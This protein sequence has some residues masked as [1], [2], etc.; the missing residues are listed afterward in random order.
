MAF[1]NLIVC[2]FLSFYSVFII[3]LLS[4]KNRKNINQK[5]K[6]LDTIRKVKYKTLEEQKAFINLKF[7]KSNMTKST[8]SQKGKATLKF[9]LNAII[10]ITI[11]FIYKYM[12]TY[13]NIN[14]GLFGLILFLILFPLIINYILSK[15]KLQHNDDFR[16]IFGNRG[17]KK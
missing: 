5:N 16:I 11:L 1:G 17:N 9:I 8:W 6:K 10:F 14:I 2:A 15:F 12:F 13:F 7:P 4:S 3:K